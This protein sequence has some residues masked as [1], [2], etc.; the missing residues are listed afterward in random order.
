MKMKFE[1]LH[2]MILSHVTYLQRKDWPSP[3]YPGPQSIFFTITTQYIIIIAP[4]NSS[5]KIHDFFQKFYDSGN[6]KR[7]VEGVHSSKDANDFGD[8]NAD[9]PLSLLSLPAIK[10]ENS[11]LSLIPETSPQKSEKSDLSEGEIKTA[12]LAAIR[13]G[14]KSPDSDPDQ[15]PD[16]PNIDSDG[17]TYTCDRCLLR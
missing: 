9:S 17:Q 13:S 2:V 11:L 5:L 14:S 10:S 15:P 6:L 7:H 3:C 12:L 16:I 8:K 4:S 1:K